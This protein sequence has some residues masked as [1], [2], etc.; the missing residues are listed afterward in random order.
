MIKCLVVAL[1][2][3]EV[4]IKEMLFECWFTMKP[5]SDIFKTNIFWKPKYLSSLDGLCIKK[6]KNKLLLN[7]LMKTIYKKNQK[8][9]E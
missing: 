2:E 3:V 7:F 5:S 1:D 8:V 4:Q 6:E 9:I